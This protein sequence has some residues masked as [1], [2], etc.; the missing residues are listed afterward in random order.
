MTRNIDTDL[1]QHLQGISVAPIFL[2]RLVFDAGIVRLW[3]GLGDLTVA[4]EIYTGAGTLLNIS[5]THETTQMK[6]TGITIRLNGLDN[7]VLSLA[8]AETYQGRRAD[9]LMGAI[10]LQTM[11]LIGAPFLAFRGRMDVMEINE[12]GAGCDV[13]L[14]CEH[15][16][17]DLDKP[18][19]RSYTSQDQAIDF[20][21]DRGLDMVP[22]LQDAAI[23]WGG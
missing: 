21:G 5:A 10:D 14:S 18:R 4:S 11:Q 6:A 20:N 23:A 9:I 16:L 8:L 3:S 13:T 17:I 12:T 19:Y 2:V 1:L 22:A 7:V 15:M